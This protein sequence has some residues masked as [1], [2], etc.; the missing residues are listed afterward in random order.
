MCM[1]DSV[2]VWLS[3]RVYVCVYFSMLHTYMCVCAWIAHWIVQTV[4]AFWHS[5]GWIACGS[6]AYYLAFVFC[7]FAIFVL[8]NHRMLKGFESFSFQL[9]ETNFENFCY[10]CC[11]MAVSSYV[12]LIIFV[13]MCVCVCSCMCA[14]LC[15]FS[16]FA[17]Q[18][19]SWPAGEIRWTL[20]RVRFDKPFSNFNKFST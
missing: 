14:F 13:N 1:C 20:Q 17:G 4:L 9:N 15:G 5:F 11:A 8:A 19:R 12:S 16:L 3:W 7:F 18:T 2:G 6:S 10:S